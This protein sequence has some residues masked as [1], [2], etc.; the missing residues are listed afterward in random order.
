MGIFSRNINS[1]EYEKLLKKQLEV[2]AELEE[3]KKKFEI[4]TTN[5]NSLRG[6]INRRIGVKE[7]TQDIN[8]PVIL[9]DNGI[10]FKN[11]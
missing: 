11:R 9:P 5:F 4:I 10:P 1:V 2:S 6:L 8:N 3:L 7:E